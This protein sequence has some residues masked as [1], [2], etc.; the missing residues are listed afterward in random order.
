MTKVETKLLKQVVQS[1]KKLV[2]GFPRFENGLEYIRAEISKEDKKMVFTA[3]DGHRIS[4]DAILCETDTSFTCYFE[5]NQIIFPDKLY[6]GK[7]TEFYIE[8]NELSV[9]SG[10]YTMKIKQPELGNKNNWKTV[11]QYL[12]D[13]KN[14]T[15]VV[16][17]GVNLT[18]LNESLKSMATTNRELKK[19]VVMSFTKENEPIVVRAL[20]DNDSL[21]FILPV[22][23]SSCE[24]EC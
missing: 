6:A 20:H 17:I 22:N 1:Y 10:I 21:R 5:P 8:E 24:T 11:D 19:N 15:S 13:V 12:E 2:Y 3:C 18:L 23:I 14:R 7:E 16:K 4:V 9:T